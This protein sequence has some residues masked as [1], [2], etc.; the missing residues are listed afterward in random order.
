MDGNLDLAFWG[1]SR[2][3]VSVIGLALF[4]SLEGNLVEVVMGAF[5]EAAVEKYIGLNA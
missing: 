4:W 1:L 3:G 5:T 2:A